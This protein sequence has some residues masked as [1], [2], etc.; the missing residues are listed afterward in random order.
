MK[1]IVMIPTYN[2]R[3]NIKPLME[4]ILRLDNNI[5]TLVVDDNSPDGT[6]RIVQEISERE[7]RVHL[8]HREKKKGRG[9]AGID[10]LRYAIEKGADYIVEMDADFSHNPKYIPEILRAMEKYDVAI[11]SRFIDGGKD[12]D[13]GLLRRLITKL[14]G[15][16]VRILLAVKIKDVS[17][18]FRC[19]RRQVLEKIDLDDMV[20]GGPSIVLELL[21]KITLNGFRIKEVPIIFE[22]RRQG[23]TKLDWITLLETM[24]MVLRLRKMQKDGLIKTA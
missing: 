11:G 8:L 14:A 6:W 24:V 3:E 17:S 21:Y 4:Q 16:Y 15:M 23:R 19:F 22:D 1:T 10:G 13:R 20:S 12:K 9:T 2:E 18:G 5:E 7:P